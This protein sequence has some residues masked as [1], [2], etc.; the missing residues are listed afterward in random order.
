MTIDRAA[1]L[2][3]LYAVERDGLDKSVALDRLA[4][5]FA[6]DP[7]PRH[8]HRYTLEPSG[9]GVGFDYECACGHIRNARPVV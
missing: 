4:K 8:R 5:C 9:R 3:I 1:A 6:P 2:A 7:K